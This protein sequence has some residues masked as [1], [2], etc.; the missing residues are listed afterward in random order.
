MLEQLCLN[1]S[2]NRDYLK[3]VG[4]NGI[5]MNLS[6]RQ[7]YSRTLLNDIK[8]TI[9]EYG[10]NPEQLEFELTESSVM[11]DV[12][13]AIEVMRG[14]Q[15]LGC[16]IAIDD[17]GTGYSSLSY[18]KRFPINNLKIDKSFIVDIPHDNHGSAIATAIIAMAIGD[19]NAVFP[20]VHPASA[21]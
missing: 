6:G 13:T 10:V 20:R 15:N 21:R 3:A 19:R 1:L 5:S 12:E 2:K 8:N 9:N 17:F 4:I 11:D 16:K 7:F 18:L 14:I